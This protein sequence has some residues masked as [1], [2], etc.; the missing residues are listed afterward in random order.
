MPVFS[1]SIRRLLQDPGTLVE[2]VQNA[3]LREDAYAALSSE[4]VL[5][6]VSASSVLFLLGPNCSEN[7]R[8]AAE[9]CLIL[10]LR[11]D[12]VR[13]PGDLCCPGGSISP[14]ADVYLAK[15]L[16]LPFF[17]L[18]RWSNW[19]SLRRR[20]SRDAFQLAVL[21]ATALR[22]SFEEMRLNPLGVKFLGLLPSE[23][24]VMFKRVIYPLVGWVKTQRRFYPNWEVEKVIHVPL[25]NLLN[26]ENYMR[27]RLKIDIP[28]TGVAAPAFKEFPCYMHAENGKD[29]RLWGAT[30]RITMNFLQRVFGFQPP[31]IEAL[32]TVEGRI[33]RAYMTGNGFRQ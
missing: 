5:N 1:E 17:S 2:H 32:P 30:F 20:R 15:L 24:L 25:R 6:S 13:Q 8:A 9:P 14:H 29:H 27:F 10:N 26:P 16:Y 23:R 4:N 21:M 19:V 3:L 7:R 18:A 22:E 31:E 12:K 33:G 28:Q 11:S